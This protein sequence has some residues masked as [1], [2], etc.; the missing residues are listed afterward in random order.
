MFLTELFVLKLSICFENNKVQ[1]SLQI[2]FITLISSHKR[3]VSG[4][5]LYFLFA[6]NNKK[7]NYENII[8]IPFN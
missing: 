4:A 2:Y 1:Y 6:Y 8:K 7:L 5:I 3:D